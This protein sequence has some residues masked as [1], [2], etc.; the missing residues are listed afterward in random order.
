MGVDGVGVEQA[1]EVAQIAV[2]DEGQCDALA[3]HAAGAAGA[4]GVGLVVEGEVEVDDVGDVREIEAAPGDIGGDHK[5]DLLL[6]EAAKDRGATVLVEAAV[7]NIDRID[8]ALQVAVEVGGLVARI[9]ENDALLD[10][11]V[12][13]VADEVLEALAADVLE[14]VDQRLRRLLVAV[15]LDALGLFEILLGQSLDFFGHSRR[16]EQ[17]LVL[18]HDAL[19]YE[20]DIFDKAHLEHFVGFVQDHG[21]DLG[22]IEAVVPDEVY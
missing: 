6:A 20:V 13:D 3:A 11:L 1:L 22:E 9:A 12:V 17:G 16:K 2:A 10:L 14:S 21:F 4:V 7:D 19:H 15:E 5:A 18:L 8:L